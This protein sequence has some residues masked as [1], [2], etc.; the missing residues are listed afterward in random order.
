MSVCESYLQ[1]SGSGTFGH[2]LRGR[3]RG[4]V[5]SAGPDDGCKPSKIRFS[6]K[7]APRAT[8]QH[9]AQGTRSRKQHTKR[10]RRRKKRVKEADT[11]PKNCQA[12]HQGA[13][14][15]PHLVSA[16]LRRGGGRTG[17]GAR[18]RRRE[19]RA[20]TKSRTAPYTGTTSPELVQQSDQPSIC[21]I[22]TGSSQN[23]CETVARVRGKLEEVDRCMAPVPSALLIGDV[24]C[25][26]APSSGSASPDGETSPV[27]GTTGSEKIPST[28]RKTGNSSD[29]TG[30]QKIDELLILQI[31]DRKQKD[32][33]K[34]SHCCPVVQC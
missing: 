22:N 10:S 29:T 24:H 15:H 5:P 31:T 27:D 2:R 16:T 18:Q 17:R 4:G 6:D 1:W 26:S 14:G 33:W 21:A 20:A 3:A 34:H 25:N 11:L 32:T 13:Q 12:P 28:Q 7:A 23:S 30:S 19:A 9:Y 8:T